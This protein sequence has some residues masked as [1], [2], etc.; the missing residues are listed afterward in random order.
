MSDRDMD[1]GESLK[2]DMIDKEEFRTQKN[3]MQI[4]V[5]G[6]AEMNA[7]G[8]STLHVMMMKMRPTDK[9]NK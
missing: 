3:A 1:W 2:N 6:K 4:D 9:E 7:M 8:D 5:T